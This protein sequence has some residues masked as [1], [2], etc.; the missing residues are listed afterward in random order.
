MIYRRPLNARR[1][2]RVPGDIEPDSELERPAR[3]DI[4]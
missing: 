2:L 4:D 3:T 1:A